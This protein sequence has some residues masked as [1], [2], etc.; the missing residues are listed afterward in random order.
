MATGTI[1]Q[2]PELTERQFERI[3]KLVGQLC[4]INLHSVTAVLQPDYF[5][6]YPAHAHLRA[7]WDLQDWPG[8]DEI[9]S[10]PDLY[11][12]SEE[13]YARCWQTNV[14]KSY[15][16][17]GKPLGLFLFWRKAVA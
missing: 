8:M 1:L 10:A 16:D 12:M 17:F 11:C 6:T 15:Q 3:S 7:H 14:R 9:L 4:G 13:A 5:W 2:R